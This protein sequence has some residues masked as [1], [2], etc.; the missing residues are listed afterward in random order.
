MA[1]VIVLVPILDEAKSRTV[2]DIHT[3]IVNRVKNDAFCEISSK[4]VFH[5]KNDYKSIE[6]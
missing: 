4:M 5:V 1:T 2:F 3:R 6:K